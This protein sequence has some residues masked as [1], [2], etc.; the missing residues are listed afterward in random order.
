[1]R[2]LL[3]VRRANIVGFSLL[4][5]VCVS[6][7]YVNLLPGM[8]AQTTLAFEG[9]LNTSMV[10][11]CV[12]LAVG[13][14]RF[15]LF[16]KADAFLLYAGHAM[17][18][19]ALAILFVP[20]PILGSAA[21]FS[22]AGVLAGFGMACAVPYYFISLVSGSAQAT[23][24]ACGIVFLTGMLI[25]VFIA[26]LPDAAIATCLIASLVGSALCLRR[27]CFVGCEE[28]AFGLQ[29]DSPAQAADASLVGWTLAKK[30]SWRDLLNAFLVPVVCTFAL[31]VVYRVIDVAVIGVGEPSAAATLVSQ[32]GG[33][34]AALVFLA[35][36][37]FR[38]S[39]SMSFLFNAVFGILA[40]GILLLPFLS[41][42]YR[43]LLNAC[44][45]AGWKLVMLSLFALALVAYAYDKRRMI[46]A[47]SLA[48]ALPR[49][50][51]LVGMGFALAFGVEK[52]PDFADAMAVAFFLLYIVL[53]AI[54]VANYHERKQIERRALE[55]NSEALAAANRAQRAEEMLQ[56]FAEEQGN[57]HL[58]RCEFLAETYALTEREK[59]I[60]VL[61]AQGRDLSF[62][63]DSLF[64][65]KNTVKSYSKSIYAKMGV[66]S[67]QAIIDMV[68]GEGMQR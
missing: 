17:M 46:V 64:L 1:M 23:I 51:L 50:G 21:C 8:N 32:C 39:T 57:A 25:N 49:L 34:A 44:A 61:L 30:A 15:S 18:L 36:F 35:Y 53:M 62:I 45:A 27:V 2:L 5:A 22:L 4:Y 33:I 14:S 60:L 66:H 6:F 31:S 3:L 16:S 37:H 59:D 11:G 68:R 47:V 38:K 19:A 10:V 20:L 54:W 63:A 29:G 41:D 43:A 55:A 67:K 24:R 13:A 48:Y 7:F 65:S 26:M 58:A 9:A 40:T 12:V 56:E 28:G 42:Q 52:A